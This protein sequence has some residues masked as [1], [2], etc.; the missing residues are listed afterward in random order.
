MTPLTERPPAAQP[1][2]L[3]AGTAP[4][5]R[6][7][8]RSLVCLVLL[9]LLTGLTLV[10]LG[11]G[12][13]PLTLG[14]VV[15]SLTGRGTRASDFIVYELRLPRVLAGLGVG[16][17]FGMSGAVCQ[18]MLRN[19]LASP[20]IIGITAGASAGA[21][22]AILGLGLSGVAVA[23][24]AFGGALLTAVAI[25]LLS[26]RQGVSGLRLV[27]VGI[28]VAAVLYSVIDFLMTRAQIYEAQEALIWL[29]GSLNRAGTTGLLPLAVVVALALALS[30]VA[31][32]TL[33]ALQ[34]GDDSAQ[35][36]GVGVERSRLL[37]LLLAVALAAVATSVAGP[38][39][40]V[41]FVSAPIARR[42]TAEA[43]P[44]LVTAG[45]VGAAV[46][47]LA[48]LAGQNLLPVAL[49]VGVL[50]AAVGAP[51]LIYLLTRGSAASA[52]ATRGVPR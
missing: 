33:S 13:F 2:A 18:T 7:R 8:R 10:A 42:L 35:A 41:A 26:W 4:R 11:L 46:V 14:E 16:F 21:V 20:D 28:G 49:P 9:G 24:A 44:G 22:L 15:S 27:L 3:D 39:G 43:G 31:A 45:L 1:G 17:A 30:P 36:L 40:F 38:V 52:P 12:D 23:G 50:T 19:P 32:R 51:Y 25:Y 29:T 6:H 37:L 47:T 34:L 5:P 48:D